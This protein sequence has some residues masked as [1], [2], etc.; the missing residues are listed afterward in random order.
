MAGSQKTVLVIGKFSYNSIRGIL[1]TDSSEGANRGIGLTII[2]TLKDRGWS[3][4]GS[5][6]PETCGDPSVEEVRTTINVY[7]ASIDL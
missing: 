6:H 3:T 2:K 4:I 1:Q 7:K 5:V